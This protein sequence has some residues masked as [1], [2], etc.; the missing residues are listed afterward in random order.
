MQRKESHSLM[1]PAVQSEPLPQDLAQCHALIQELSATLREEQRLRARSEQRVAQL[2]QRLFG[3]RAERVDPAQLLLFGQEVAA[4]EADVARE[5]EAAPAPK[6]R[7]G[8]GRKPLPK[9]LPRHRIEHDVPA[10]LKR[11]PECG[12]D[13]KRI[14]EEISEQLDYVPASVFIIEHVRPKY[15]CPCCQEH[16]AIADKPA[17]VIAKGLPG[18]GLAA[19]V[20]TSKYC[21]HIPLYRQEFTL[22]R[23][24]V[25]LSRKTLC[26][27]VMRTAD[28]AAPLA[29]LMRQ[30]VLA[31]KVIGTDDTPVRVQGGTNNGPFTGRFWVYV[32]D[33]AHPYTVY[34]YTP[35]RQRDG[36][37]A[38]LE[39]YTGYLQAD[40]F[41]GYDGLYASGGVKEVACWAH[42]RRYFYNA[43]A[44]D[45]E[46]AHRAL[47]W[48]RQLYGVE[49]DAKKQARGA[50]ARHALRQERAKPL[51][52]GD[53]A[54]QGLKAWLIEQQPKVL[55]KSP[56]GEAITY[57]LNNWAA[58]TRYLDDG[59]LA[60]DN[61]KAE[62]ALRGIAIGRKNWLFLGSGRGGRAAA[63]HYTL[64]QSA[65]RHGLD[66]FAYL[67]DL[68]PR[69]ATQP[70]LDLHELLP[71]RWKASLQA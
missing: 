4:A 22:A 46:R 62:Q 2:L 31:S 1:A 18:P 55:P 30:S 69:L 3:P 67:R 64:I 42:C 14:G 57:A 6:P 20:I 60:I 47:A 53:G 16:V 35:T 10:H 38:F 19:H 39:G 23:H 44:T 26:G 61:N 50:D 29:D 34:D 27:W 41:A 45:P 7:K 12:T 40:A 11:C 15:A 13:K 17:K 9:E 51:F 43:R 49:R 71:D 52:E 68:L 65:R 36:P 21:D 33:D 70:A 28:A 8:H 54:N 48:V 63:I 24:G 37:A 56:I 32:G 66:P 5:E 25:R 59:M 58:L